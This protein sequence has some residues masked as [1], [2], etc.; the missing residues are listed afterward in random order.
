MREPHRFA[1]T[2][3]ASPARLLDTRA[4]GVTLDGISAG[5]GIRAAGSVQVLQIANRAG[6]PPAI[7][8]VVLN[9][10]VDQAQTAGF[11]TVYPCD[12]ALPTASNVNYIAGQTIP[13]AVIAKVGSAGT[14]CRFTSGVTHLIV[15]IAGYFADTTVRV[16]LGAPARLLDTRSDGATFDGLFKATGLRPTGGT[17]RLDVIGRA[18]IPANASAVALE[19]HRGSGPSRRFHHGV[20]NRRGTAERV[21]PQLRRGPNCAERCDRTPRKWWHALPVQ[22]CRHPP[23]RRHRRLPH[24]SRT[25]RIGIVVPGRPGPTADADDH[26]RATTA[27]D[28]L[29]WTDPDHPAAGRRDRSTI[30]DLHSSKGR[31]IWA[32]L[33][34]DRCR[35]PVV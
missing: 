30:P 21:E 29:S 19:R 32:V 24:R 20:P 13:N 4:A 25:A 8:S 31:R 14:V 6:V 22:Q 9:V 27:D 15:D 17:I 10:T 7:A 11:I 34:R 35:I 16:P 12:A 23:D 1:G 18:G 5:G 26:D 2:P 33:P 3:L 28:H